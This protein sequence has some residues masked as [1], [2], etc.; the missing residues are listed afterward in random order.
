M[1]L[2]PDAVA[3]ADHLPPA[4]QHSV[5]PRPQPVPDA[6]F[7]EAAG[8]FSAAGDV[9]RLRLLAELGRGERCVTE[10]ADQFGAGLSTVSQRL[11]VLRAEGLV[12][13]RRQ[14]KHVF[15]SLADDHVA[16][17]VTSA[18]AHASERTQR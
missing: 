6:A 16:D 14:G 9:A 10:L 8:L 12:A 2:I 7:E 3:D 4:H 13:R 5:H 18:L 15:Y 17:L 1:D 11:R